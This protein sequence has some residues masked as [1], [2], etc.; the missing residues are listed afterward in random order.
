MDKSHSSL[1]TSNL[2][3]PLEQYVLAYR[4]AIMGP[5]DWFGELQH[6]RVLADIEKVSVIGRARLYNLDNIS[7]STLRSILHY[8]YSPSYYRVLGSPA[9]ISGCIK[10]MS[11]IRGLGR[12]SSLGYELGYACLQIIAIGLGACLLQS[13]KDLGFSVEES[14]AAPFGPEIPRIYEVSQVTSQ[15]VAELASHLGGSLVISVSE[16]GALLNLLYTDRH[17]FLQVMRSTYLQGLSA[18]TFVLWRYA[19][20]QR[21]LKGSQETGKHFASLQEVL[22]RSWLVSTPHEQATF[23]HMYRWDK[24]LWPKGGEGSTVTAELQD[25]NTVIGTFIERL[26]P[27]VGAGRK[28]TLP[29]S[30][31]D[32]I[33]AFNYVGNYFRPGCE[34]LAAGYFGVVVEHMWHILSNQE[35]NVPLFNRAVGTSML[36]MFW[37]VYPPQITHI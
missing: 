27:A 7:I 37:Y 32:L 16:A 3:M 21:S 29:V 18:V 33:N 25:S 1:A 10:I 8:S 24:G 30:L 26:E 12:E 15:L 13:G 34:G 9:L 20:Y 28:V 5:P 22:W 11:S 17:P 6:E 19:T 23:V 4:N 35:G 2:G 36:S 31:S 14:P